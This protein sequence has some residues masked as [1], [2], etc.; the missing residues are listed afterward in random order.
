[1]RA[2]REALGVSQGRLGRQLGL[3]FSQIQKYEKGS[4]RIGAGRLYQIAV[5]LNVPLSYFFEGLEGATPEVLGTPPV[6]DEASELVDAF[7]AIAGQGTRQSV[8]A[9]VRSLSGRPPMAEPA[10]R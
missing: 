9:L 7:R 4:N 10:E 3:T 2:R 8:L 6:R 1:M 5:F